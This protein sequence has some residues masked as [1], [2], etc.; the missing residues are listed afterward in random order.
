MTAELT[1]GSS[2]T[3]GGPAP[4]LGVLLPAHW[5]AVAEIY[6]QGIE[7]GDA[8]FETEVPTWEAW[9]AAHLSPHRFVAVAGR[10]IVGWVAASAV[11]DRCVYAGVV[12]HS[13]YV[14][15]GAR[16]QGVGLA[17]IGQLVRS[18]EQ[19]GIW[20]VQTGIFP[21]NQAGV[22]LHE[23]AGFKVV[24]RRERLGRLNGVWRDVLFLE[25]RSKVAG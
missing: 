25:R 4:V 16:R 3:L 24:G 5:P 15:A 18:T 13:V 2:A 11:S 17:L 14:A 9:D 22:R 7:T 10:N 1:P 20:T 6:R 19:A 21:E 23:Q 12:E 8:T